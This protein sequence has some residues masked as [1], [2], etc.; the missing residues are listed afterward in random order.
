MTRLDALFRHWRFGIGTELRVNWHT[1]WFGGYVCFA[2]NDGQVPV[3]LAE[4]GVFLGPYKVRAAIS[5]RFAVSDA[6]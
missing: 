3:M 5:K 6:R 1:W 4:I 2:D